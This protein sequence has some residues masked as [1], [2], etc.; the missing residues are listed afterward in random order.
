MTNTKKKLNLP[1]I[2]LAVLLAA[3]AIL[4]VW[5]F[6][7]AASLEAR[8]TEAEA[9]LVQAQQAGSA[10]ADEVARLS[11]DL[12]AAQQDQMETDAA[13]TAAQE[14]LAVAEAALAEKEAALT[15][16]AEEAVALTQAKAD[17]EAQV[18]A[19][20]EELTG[21]QAQLEQLT[22]EQENAMAA[23]AALGFGRI[24]PVAEEPVTE[25]PVT[26]EPVADEP[27]A[28]EPVAEEPVTEEPV[29][30]AAASNVY[31]ADALKLVFEAPAGWLVDDSADNAFILTDPENPMTC[32][33]ISA[34]EGDMDDAALKEA[35]GEAL[36]VIGSG[37]EDFVPSL[38]AVRTLLGADGVY[39]SYQVAQESGEVFGKVHMACVDGVVYTLHITCPLA[40]QEVYTESV[41]EL[42]RETV[43]FA[44]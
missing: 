3:A 32:L 12:T 21:L 42:F 7:R 2:V 34:A 38:F 36:N 10:T 16:S 6:S 17:A 40:E 37:R 18:A 41:Y 14:A 33:T 30:E 23:L 19:L 8:L 44:Q 15:A 27:V 25:E 13:L 24:E 20:T 11:A 31:T 5:A 4:C 28:E 26:E 39:A 29:P 35:L 43:R 9:A 1:V 22:T